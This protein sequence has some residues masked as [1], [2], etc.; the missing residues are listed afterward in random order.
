MKEP[1]RFGE[2]TE[3]ADGIF[4]IP[5]DYPAVADAP[6]WTHLLRGETATLIDCGVPS[7]YDAVFADA[8]AHIGK[9]PG[10]VLISF[11]APAG[12]LGKGAVGNVEVVRLAMTHTTFKELASLF[13]YTAS[14]LEHT[15]AAATPKDRWKAWTRLP[16]AT[17]NGVVRIAMPN[18]TDDC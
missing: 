5:T 18:A 10:I 15:N 11:A 4:S 3:V 17:T 9:G 6:L 13:S 7:T 14:E 16:P 1:M 12:E 2:P 8:F